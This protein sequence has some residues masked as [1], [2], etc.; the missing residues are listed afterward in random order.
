MAKTHY[1]LARYRVVSSAAVFLL[2]AAFVPLLLV[3]ISLPIVKFIYI[4]ALQTT[5]QVQTTTVAT[6]L[7]LG[8]WGI[9]AANAIGNQPETLANCV[10]PQL[11]Y[12]IPSSLTNLVGLT[13]QAASILSKAL[14]VLLILHPIAAGLALIALFFSL[15]LSST[16]AVILALLAAVLSGLAGIIVLAAD[17]AVIIIAR[18]KI[19]TLTNSQFTVLFGNGVWLVLAS[20]CVTWVACFVLLARTCHCCGVRR[21]YDDDDYYNH[22]GYH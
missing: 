21:R 16:C 7:R 1:P 10:G 20:V 4:L 6:E 22:Y 13:P 19:Q 17:I 8:V 9:C 3:A 14:L 5:T 18:Q 2:L 15:F 12:H 11:G